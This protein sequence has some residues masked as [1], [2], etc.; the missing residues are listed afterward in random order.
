MDPSVL[1]ALAREAGFDRAAIVDPLRLAPWAEMHAAVLRGFGAAGADETEG[2]EWEWVLHPEGWSESFTLLVCCLS[3]FRREPDDLS[4]PGEPHALIAPFARA[5]YYRM[6]MSMLR[7]F[8]ERLHATFGIPRTGLRFFSNS[9]I[10]EK[11]LL[12][13]S[14]LGTYGKN[15]L[16]LVPGL[17]SLFIIAGAVIPLPSPRSFSAVPA[18]AEDPCGSCS[19]CMGACPTGAIVAPGIVDRDRCLQGS[20]GCS[21][22]LAPEV[23]RLRGARLYGCQSCQ[24]VCPHNSGLTEGAAPACGEIGPSLP[25]RRILGAERPALKGL[26]QGTAMGMSWVASDALLRNALIAAGNRGDPGLRT[27]VERFS[28]STV[29]ALRAAARWALQQLPAAE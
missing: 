1:S 28:G 11:P 25:L 6:A 8:G 10:P 18:A 4:T 29:P 19:L 22:A 14:G 20:A 12:A 26:F 23:M 27:A 15:G 17:G 16:T 24:D 9:R 2:L 13:A 7:A 5:H 21:S 3:C